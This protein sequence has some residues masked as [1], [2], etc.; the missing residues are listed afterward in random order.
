LTKKE[1]LVHRDDFYECDV[2]YDGWKF[3]FKVCL[4]ER[5]WFE[6]ESFFPLS[7][8]LDQKRNKKVKKLES[9]P[10]LAYAG[11]VQFLPYAP[12]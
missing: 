1:P 8:L 4:G 6:I 10:A 5:T 11:P 2:F 7:F 3:E 12:T 9:S